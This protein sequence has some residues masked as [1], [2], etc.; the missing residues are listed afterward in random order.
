MVTTSFRGDC[1]LAVWCRQKFAPQGAQRPQVVSHLK[2]FLCRMR[3]IHAI[4]GP[5]SGLI[6]RIGLRDGSHDPLKCA[7]NLNSLDERL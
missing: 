3:I 2:R 6:W 7:A 1:R 5:A 4:F